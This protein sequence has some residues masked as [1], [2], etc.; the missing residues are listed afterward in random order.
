MK[1]AAVKKDK[2]NAARR[3]GIKCPVPTFIP[4]AMTPYYGGARFPAA[5]E[6]TA[7]YLTPPAPSAED[8]GAALEGVSLILENEER[9]G[10]DVRENASLYF[11]PDVLRR[12]ILALGRIGSGKTQRVMYPLIASTLQSKSA[13]LVILGTKG[14]EFD[15]VSAM[16]EKYRP[17]GKV[18]CVNFANAARS[19]VGWNPFAASYAKDRKSA[20]HENANVWV[21]VGS[22]SS[23]EE[24]P[25]WRDSATQLIAGIVLW[26]ES[27][28]RIARPVDVYEIVSCSSR[29]SDLLEGANG[30]TPFLSDFMRAFQD[31]NHNMQTV[32][33]ET[34][35]YVRH[36]IDGD[37][38]AV[39]SCD[40][41]KFDSLFDEPTVFVL[42]VT[43]DSIR[44]VRPFINMI[45]GQLLDA[46]PRRASRDPNAKL[47]RPLYFFLDDFAAA[48]GTIPDCASRINTLRSMD[49]RFTLAL[50][51]RGQLYEF[52]T[53]GEADA[54]LSACGTTLYIPPVSESDAELGSRASGYATFASRPSGVRSSE[55][56]L[57]IGF[58]A[59]PVDAKGADS[60]PYADGAFGRYLLLPNDI[61]MSTEHP[62]YGQ[63]AT[64]FLPG[65][66][67]FQAYLPCAY[68]R[69]DLAEFVCAGKSSA[70]RPVPGSE[71][72]LALNDPNWETALRARA[73]ELI[74]NPYV[75]EL[76]I[77]FRVR[78]LLEE[79]GYAD[80]NEK[81]KE[82]FDFFIAEYK[83][84]LDVVERTLQELQK[85]E[86][87]ITEFHG[88]YIE[89]DSDNIQANL[90]YLD[91]D[92]IRREEKKTAIAK[93]LSDHIKRLS[94]KRAVDGVDSEE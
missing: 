7:P 51:S 90:F 35:G 52:Y 27:K 43:Q 5:E 72:E 46:V 24:S 58:G 37:L 77:E 18:A 53:P 34:Q 61:S 9:T 57:Q 87:T 12:N 49:V 4:R 65:K 86:A 33:T 91:Y 48:V 25:F 32:L 74:N 80:A 22:P 39:T 28:G 64:V 82:W 30:P 29:L 88:A 81:V 50:Q 92:R 45:L 41:F 1:R 47:P 75:P 83:D 55:N 23:K 70:R 89:S 68:Q 60:D 14:N 13:S 38:A 21:N 19:T 8:K 94:A 42:E 69:K 67:P 84:R 66:Y 40:D 56:R 54:I 73:I 71:L 15:A 2:K 78:T 11:P 17:G 93:L 6:L 36:M 3:N 16:C 26:I 10:Y 76:P 20:A 44:R 62:T 79:C 63:A 59:R 85:R 31:D